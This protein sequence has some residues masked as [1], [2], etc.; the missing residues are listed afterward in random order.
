MHYSQTTKTQSQRENLE[1][2]KRITICCV[3]M[4]LNKLT[5]VFSSETTEAK[6]LQNDMFQVV[7]GKKK[8]TKNSISSKTIL[9]NEGKMRH[10]QI[11]KS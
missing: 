10:S 1:G 7:G 11:N 2:S 3:Q 4:I 9:Q 5:I 8:S 6:M